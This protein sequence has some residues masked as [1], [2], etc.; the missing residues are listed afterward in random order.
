V[1]DFEVTGFS[2]LEF[3]PAAVL[4]GEPVEL[5][6]AGEV[7]TGE[8]IVN[9]GDHSFAVAV[10]QGDLLSVDG[11][12]DR[13][14]GEPQLGLV[15]GGDPEVVGAADRG[16]EPAAEAG[17]VA[18]ALGAFVDA[19]HQHAFVGRAQEALAGAGEVGDVGATEVQ[20]ALAGQAG[21]EVFDQGRV[22]PVGVFDEVGSAVAVGI[23]GFGQVGIGEGR[24]VE[25][26][27]PLAEGG[28]D[29][30]EVLAEVHAVFGGDGEEERGA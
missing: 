27:E 4:A 14:V 20:P 30:D 18:R 17:A 28:V 15:V 11:P 29:G 21:G 10:G 3:D 22:E 24:E 16:D 2:G 6:D 9:R 5:I 8:R 1:E 7:L 23:T 25:S 13:A 26:G 19:G 12:G